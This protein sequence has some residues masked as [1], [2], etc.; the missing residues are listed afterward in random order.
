VGLVL[1]CDPKIIRHAFQSSW[2]GVATSPDNGDDRYYDDPAIGALTPLSIVMVENSVALGRRMV[3][4]PVLA[5]PAFTVC[6]SA[7]E[8]ATIA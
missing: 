8:E 6:L 5:L 3:Q 7:A 2:Q 4:H 1:Q